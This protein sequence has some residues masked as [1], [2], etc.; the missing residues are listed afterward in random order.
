MLS[1]AAGLVIALGLIGGGVFA[2]AQD[3]PLTSLDLSKVRQGYGTP[4]IDKAVTGVPLSIGGRQFTTGLGA[5]AEF[6]M[7]IDLKGG[8]E[9]FEAWVGVDDNAGKG[10]GSVIFKVLGDGKKLYQSRVMRC[11]DPAKRVDVPL[12]GVMHLL[13]MVSDAGDGINFDHADWA[14]AQFIGA[15]EKPRTIDQPHEPAVILTPKPS[16]KPRINGARV[17]GVRP[18]HLVLFTIAATGDRPMTFAAASLPAGLS[19]DFKTGRI[20]GSVAKRGTY[21][22]V[23]SAKNALGIATREFRIIVGDQIALTPPMG[24][25]DWYTFTSS[26][27]DKDVRASADAMVANGMINHGY[28]YVNI[29]DCWSVKVNSD[30]PEIG[31]PRRDAQGN[32]LSNKRFPDM[33][34]LTDYIHSKGLRAGIYISPGPWT[35]AYYEGSYGHEAQ[36]AKQFANWGFDF[37]KY[38]FCSYR[39]VWKGD[40]L[41]EQK[42][43]Y[44][45][46][47]D[48]LKQ[49]DRDMVFNLCQ[50]GM[51]SVWEWGREVGGNSWRTAGD[52][53]ANPA[54]YS[55]GFTLDG[56]EK[57]VGPGHW[58]DPD[59]I[60]IGWL[61][62]PTLL[63]PNE[64]YTYV[65]LWSMLAAPL[66]FSG[67]MTK[68]D[69]FTLSLLTN[70]DVIDVDQDPLGIQAHRVSQDNDTEVWVKNLEDGSK[71]VGLFNRNE[72]PLKITAKWSDID[73]TGKQLV[74]DLWRQ[75]DLG[76]YSG[77]FEAEVPRHGA[78]MLRLW[79]AK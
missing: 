53:G 51:A 32:V 75:K 34:A 33:K 56:R 67:D 12:K 52:I 47:G 77:S 23:L 11:G 30:D 20:S 65:S 18:G 41:E 64:Q 78:S 27:T 5:H 70:D 15:S 40:T 55:V 4:Q 58:N 43:P 54:D 71:A 61:G 59:Y 42:R 45:L 10:K 6:L 76:S 26:I 1:R 35:C 63:T 24:W 36:D 13:L 37:L 29:D 19:V 7:W 68:L 3:I 39:N 28:S 72:F 44:K 66:I 69:D 57:W 17:F 25:N 31:G 49:Q 9:R 14:E 74:R 46:M 79:P 16:P 22:V 50:Y 60:N 21:T 2:A 73:V 62:S 48:L 8:V 38:D